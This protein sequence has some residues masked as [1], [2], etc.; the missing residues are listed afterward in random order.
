M[1]TSRPIL[2]EPVVAILIDLITAKFKSEK[3]YYTRDDVP[4]SANKVGLTNPFSWT[5]MLLDLGIVMRAPDLKKGDRY[6]ELERTLT[7]LYCYLLLLNGS[8]EAY[9]FFI[10]AQTMIP[11]IKKS[12]WLTRE[13]FDNIHSRLHD[14]I[15]TDDYCD[16]RANVLLYLIVYSDLGKSPAIKELLRK[17]HPDFNLQ[18]NPDGLMT[19][20]LKL[21]DEEIAAILPGFEDLSVYAKKMLREAYPIMNACQGHIYFLERGKRTFDIVAK[22][23]EN[24]PRENRATALNLVDAAQF[25]DAMGA[26]GQKNI[27]G[28]VTCTEP[29]AQGYAL[30]H[31]EL[32]LLE[33]AMSVTEG[34]DDPVDRAA[35]IA[36][37]E[38]LET[39]ATWLGLKAK[40]DKQPLNTTQQLLTRLGCCIR[41][42]TPEFGK[43]VKEEYANVAP[44]H[45]LLETQ[46]GFSEAGLEGWPTVDYIATA[47]QNV[48]FELFNQANFA[49][50]KGD[51]DLASCT[52]SDAI[53]AAIDAAICFSMLLK[54]IAENYPEYVKDPKRAISF[55]SFAFDTPLEEF[56]PA[57]FNPKLYFFDPAQGKVKKDLTVVTTPAPAVVAK[58]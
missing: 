40:E 2:F 35:A 18:Q 15:G 11:E 54:H 53:K 48:A 8:D 16:D 9:N 37:N 55:A 26:Q 21:T 14:V 47:L 28:S 10:A 41:G 7:S 6:Q 12:D 19:D 4:H 43:K 22:A 50:N 24:I 20:I 42:A 27:F 1:S 3:D 49:A 29:F 39:R 32:Q 56:N 38:Y 34:I 31:K 30:V 52:I 13:S 5:S 51:E 46:L 33:T 36:F 58:I 17:N 45:E 44:F 25:I 23:L 57:T